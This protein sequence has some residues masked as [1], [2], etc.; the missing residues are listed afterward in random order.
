[1]GLYLYRT[2]GASSPRIREMLKRGR[3]PRIGKMGFWA[4][5]L[6]DLESLW[7]IIIYT[8]THFIKAGDLESKFTADEL[9]KREENE[10]FKSIFS[11]PTYPQERENFLSTDIFFDYMHEFSKSFPKMWYIAKFMRARLVDAYREREYKLD[12]TKPILILDGC[13]LHKEIL[14][15]MQDAQ[16]HPC[17]DVD[18]DI[19]PM[20]KV[21]SNNANNAPKTKQSSSEKTVDLR[22][23][24]GD[25]RRVII[26]THL[27]LSE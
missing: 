11:N 10:I 13:T 19:I 23:I 7:W 18:V 21:H 25:I 24:E 5:Y 9:E 15:D 1:M 16:Q 27:A 2:P 6:H 12:E 14:Q 4:N 8:M 20:W 26:V 3:L 22:G 17:Q